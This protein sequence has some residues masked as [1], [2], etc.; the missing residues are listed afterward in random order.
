MNGVN[1]I[2]SAQLPTRAVEQLSIHEDA[3][4]DDLT[5][6]VVDGVFFCENRDESMAWVWTLGGDVEHEP[7][8]WEEVDAEAFALLRS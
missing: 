8:A 6:Y 5:F 7:F 1:I 2:T 4:I 3:S